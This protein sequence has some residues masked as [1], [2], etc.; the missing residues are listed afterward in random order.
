M[1]G[2]VIVFDVLETLLDLRALAPAMEQ[3][4]GR[5]LVD[6]WYGQMIRS[7]M[8]ATMVG[9][10]ADLSAMGG[11][12]L[13]MV[14]GR[15]GLRLPA[16]GA[17][18]ILAGV[19]RLPPH[20]DVR[21]ALE[22]LRGAGFRLAAL[23]NSTQVTIEAQVEHARLADLFDRVLSVD[24]VR[25]FKPAPEV[26]RHAAAELGAPIGAIRLVAVHDWDVAGALGAGAAAAFVARRG[27][28]LGPL[29]LRPD[30]VGRDLVDVA[31]QIIARDG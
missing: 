16:E 4:L 24:P 26:Y 6:E 5:D 20:P 29:S 3:E 13:E 25:K 22:R 7:A 8:V 14:A 12:A 23:T 10:Y 17:A 28:V 27:M 18:R 30:I 31:D 21:P 19:R 2:R 1:S 9:T 15:H 11:H